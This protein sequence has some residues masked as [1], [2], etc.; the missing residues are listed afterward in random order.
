MGRGG[1]GQDPS[2]L[3]TTWL[4]QGWGGG[5]FGPA[6]LFPSP[7]TKLRMGPASG[8][9]LPSHTLIRR[10]TGT[11]SYHDVK[12]KGLRGRNKKTNKKTERFSSVCCWGPREHRLV[13]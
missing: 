6:A 2:Y 5:R 1:S 3:S 13:P 4:A 11:R 10:H 12:I 9:A 8:T 7:L